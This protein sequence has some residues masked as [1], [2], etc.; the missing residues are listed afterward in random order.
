MRTIIRIRI[1]LTACLAFLGTA[2]G[3][4]APTFR[5]NV[6]TVSSVGTDEQV[7]HYRDAKLRLGTDGTWQLES[8]KAVGGEVVMQNGTVVSDV[9][10][11]LSVSS[12][13]LVK[14][15]GTPVQVFLR[16]KGE[17]FGGCASLGAVSQRL[18]GNRFEVLLTDGTPGSA[19]AVMLCTADV[20]AYAWTVPLATYGLSAGTYSY[21]VNGEITGNFALDA[22]NV[23]ADGCQG[24]T[25]CQR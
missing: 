14:T 3:E 6:L 22:D 23:M 20:R 1:G 9:L 18:V 15:T 24:V 2:W 8:V 10:Y 7:G 21:I 13:E 17:L 19:Y 12:V 11:K 4:T 5:D 16:V 25:V